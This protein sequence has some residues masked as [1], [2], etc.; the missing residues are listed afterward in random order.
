MGRQRDRQTQRQRDRELTWTY[1]IKGS[2]DA[3]RLKRL[4]NK[5]ASVRSE[6]LLL[7]LMVIEIS[8]IPRHYKSLPLF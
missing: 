4:T 8:W 5:K 3:T 1:N 2:N 7:N 6:L